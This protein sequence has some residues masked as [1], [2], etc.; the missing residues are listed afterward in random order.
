MIRRL[1][2]ALP[3]GPVVRAG[4]LVVIAV[5]VLAG[6]VVFYEWLGATLLDS[7]GTIG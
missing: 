2:L 5:A 3:G 7:G 6:L 1:A 4:L